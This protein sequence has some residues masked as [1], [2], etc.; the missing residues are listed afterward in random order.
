MF[1]FGRINY[2]FRTLSKNNTSVC[3]VYW[4]ISDSADLSVVVKFMTVFVTWRDLAY[5]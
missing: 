2:K 4:N 3:M 1:T 5:S